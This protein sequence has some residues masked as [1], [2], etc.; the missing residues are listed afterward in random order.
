MEYIFI[1]SQ[2]NME[3]FNYMFDVNIVGR[4]D[5][6][7][8][9]ET[10]KNESRMFIVGTYD[11]ENP[12]W[13]NGRSMIYEKDFV[14]IEDFAKKLDPVDI[15]YIKSKRVFIWGT[16]ETCHNLEQMLKTNCWG[17]DVSGYID[18]SNKITTLNGL[19]VIPPPAY[20]RTSN[21]Y[22]IVGSIYYDAI[23]KQLEELG[24]KEHRDFECYTIFASRPSHMFK[25][26]YEDNPIDVYPC[27]IPFKR[28]TYTCFGDYPCCVSWVDFPIG[29]AITNTPE[30][31]WQSVTMK[32][33]R[34]S[35]ENMTFSFCK[36]GVCQY[37]PKNPNPLNQNKKIKYITE[38]ES[39][40][41]LLVLGLDDSCNLHCESCRERVRIAQGQL[42]EE[43][44]KYAKRLLKSGFLNEADELFMSVDGE[45]FASKV[46]RS[47]LF[48]SDFSN[49]R[50]NVHILSNGTLLDE[51]TLLKLTKI[52]RKIRISLSID[53]AT[54]KTYNML[55]RGGDWDRLKNNLK[56]IS[57]YREKG[58]ISYVDLRMVVQEKNYLEM[59]EF[60]IMAKKYNFDEV[61][62]SRISNYGTYDDREFSKISMID[63]GTNKLDDRLKNVLKDDI[64][65]DKMVNID[66]FNLYI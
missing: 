20:K 55:R 35:V 14:R 63:T 24:Y 54:K 7:D 66:S 17:I 36:K 53:A 42:L 46:D 15:E 57:E 65:K 44:I 49:K 11:A 9:I 6:D 3:D 19:P 23:K 10:E 37:L 34:L 13:E 51:D 39:H 52:Y 48:D 47:I 33:Y 16:G 62:F 40:P 56:R 4:V 60:V 30:E 22:I 61:I 5:P 58:E 27:K 41:K 8:Y 31:S 29:N 1:G 59:K 32:L 28:L 2:K 21:M 50:K 64:F 45:V 38:V 12:K 25:K 26:T 18:N 43:R